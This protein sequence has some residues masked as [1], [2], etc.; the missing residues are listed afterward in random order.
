MEMPQFS[1]T[2]L[3]G[4][5]SRHHLSLRKPHV[6]R[7]TDPD[8]DA[9]CAFIAEMDWIMTSLPMEKVINVDETCWRVV[10]GQLRTV[11]N[12][13]AGTVRCRF[14]CDEKM[15][16]TV[17]AA[18]SLSG[19]KLPLWVIKKGRTVRC[20]ASIR[21]ADCL[22]D[23]LRNG[24]LFVTHSDSGWMEK[25][26]AKKYLLWLRNR[27]SGPLGLVWDVF[28]AHRDSE[29]KETAEE[30][31]ITVTFIPAGQTDEWQPLDRRI[32]GSLKQRAIG[33]WSRQFLR[34]MEPELSVNTAL[35]NL[36][37]SWHSIGEEEVREAW[38]HLS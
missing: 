10:D 30:A 37:E 5:L 14:P 1:Y 35:L 3:S 31:E 28:A 27:Y 19:S 32:F 34:D 17:I 24:S 8:D 2:W 11:A 33:R 18:V 9:V 26:L 20:E 6:K 7:R 36:L 25:N 22:A 12:T 21:G 15:S 23:A 38:D 29:V 4:F 16:V 13:G